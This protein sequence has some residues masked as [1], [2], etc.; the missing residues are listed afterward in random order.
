MPSQLSRSGEPILEVDHIKDLAL[1]G[2]DHPGNMITLCPN[3]HAVNTRGKEATRL[4]KALAKTAF[5]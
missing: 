2:D 1:G 4:R 3:C 5:A